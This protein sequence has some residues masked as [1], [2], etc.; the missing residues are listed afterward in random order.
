MPRVPL[1]LPIQFAAVWLATFLAQRQTQRIEY[2]KAENRVL[3][4]RLGDKRLRFTNRERRRLAIAGQRVGRR[5]LRDLS[6]LATPDTILRWYRELVARKY[7]GSKHRGPGRPRKPGA[8]T[9]TLLRMARDNP[10]WGYGRLKGALWNLRHEISCTTIKRRLHEHGIEPAPTRR[11]SMD[12]ATFIRAHAGVICAADFFTVEI[13]SWLGLVRLHVFFVIDIA[14]RRVHIAGIT[15]FPSAD[16]LMQIFR[17]LLDAEDGFL[18]NHRHIILDRDPVYA[19]DVR[20]R[21]RRAGLKPVVLP[22]HSPDLNAYAERFI[23]SI[24]S[25]CLDRIVPLGQAHLRH[26]ID[27]Y[28]AHYHTERNHQ[29]LG[30]RLIDGAAARPTEGTIDRKVRLGG[31]LSYYHRRTEGTRR[32]IEF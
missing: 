9:R 17:N 14:T 6:V 1:P 5:D 3:R 11:K 22:P 30:N 21:L 8:I 23:L 26:A 7:D 24:R 20:D 15:R 13:V 25:E 28:V 32:S 29:G 2:L 18:R 4:E 10:T 12:W 16:W 31:L 19:P 27:E